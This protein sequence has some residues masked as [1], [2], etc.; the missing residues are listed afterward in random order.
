MACLITNGISRVCDFAVGGIK[1]SIWLANA[2]DF[3]ATYDVTGE[4]TGFTSGGTGATFYEFQQE[5]E[6]ASLTQTLNAGAVSRFI[7]QVLVLSMAS[8]TQAKIETLNDLALSP[9]IAI[10]KA[11]DGNWYWV[12]DNGSSLKATA[13]EVTTGMKDADAALATVTLTATNK[14]YAPTVSQT[15]LTQLGIS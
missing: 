8:L 12:G 9:L 5:L 13:L 3:Q 14:G 15:V 11:N 7:S 1:S 4:I 6:S 10:F 2:E